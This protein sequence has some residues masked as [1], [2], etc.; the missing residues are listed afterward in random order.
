MKYYQLTLRQFL[1]AASLLQATVQNSLRNLQKIGPMSQFDCIHDPRFQFL[2]RFRISK[3][4][5]A[6]T[7]KRDYVTVSDWLAITLPS[8]NVDH[9]ADANNRPFERQE[10]N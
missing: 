4:S 6:A 2:N 10:I 7:P 9:V 1:H 3:H 8:G 5:L